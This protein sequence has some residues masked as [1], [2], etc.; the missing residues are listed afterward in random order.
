MVDG[1]GVADSA[2]L[3]FKNSNAI[4]DSYHVLEFAEVPDHERLT[5]KAQSAVVLLVIPLC[6]N[7]LYPGFE[8]FVKVV[9]FS[10]VSCPLPVIVLLRDFAHD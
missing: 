2:D 1:W 8:S 4:V 7:M 6:L 9:E 10:L 5:V 3:A